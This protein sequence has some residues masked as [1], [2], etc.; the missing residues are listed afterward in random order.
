MVLGYIISFNCSVIN[1]CIFFRRLESVLFSAVIVQLFMSTY[2]HVNN[3][4][5]RIS[6][7][8]LVKSKRKFRK[9]NNLE[10]IFLF[11]FN[12]HLIA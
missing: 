5:D 8:N 6:R 4:L 3:A 9:D 10:L 12:V 2:Q 7:E 11:I 1:W